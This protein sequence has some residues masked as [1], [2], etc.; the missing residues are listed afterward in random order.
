METS[1]RSNGVDVFVDTDGGMHTFCLS[2][3]ILSGNMYEK[4]KLA[5][6]PHLFEHAVFSSLYK[7]TDGQI[8]RLADKYGVQINAATYKEFTTFYVKGLPEGFD[9]A[10]SV[11]AMM[12]DPLDVTPNDLTVERE[13]V[14]AEIKEDDDK[15]NIDCILSKAVWEGTPLENPVAGSLSI[16]SGTGVKRLERYRAENVTADNTFI[17]VT[18]CVTDTGIEKLLETLDRLPLEKTGTPHGNIAPVPADF[19]KRNVKT[20]L[21][22]SDYTCAGISFDIDFT[23]YKDGVAGLLSTL[24][25]DGEN[26][27][28]YGALSYGAH[29]LVYSIDDS[30]EQYSNVGK[31][32]FTYETSGKS[33]YDSFE[34]TAKAL[35]SVRRGEFDFSSVVTGKRLNTALW[36]DDPEAC[37]F[38]KAYTGH[39]LKKDATDEK[40]GKLTKDDIIKAA[41]EIF[42]PSNLTVAVKGDKKK[43]S[44]D[45]IKEIFK[46]LE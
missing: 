18:G 46:S 12:F 16:V 14:K 24:L 45:R 13:R 32:S 27:A 39:I 22:Q 42:K 9:F 30:L 6:L 25:F 38:N 23:R 7:K 35:L 36:L 15:N 2:A 44:V 10:C 5:G 41:N 40:Y 37:N 29:P 31:I 26:S 1:Y 20:V 8:Y 19:E 4:S 21:K 11:M 28:M 33:L 3:Y 17:Y 43:I 34:C